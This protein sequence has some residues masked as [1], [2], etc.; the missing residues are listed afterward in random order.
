[1]LKE[2]SAEDCLFIILDCFLSASR[3]LDIIEVLKLVQYLDD[4]RS[5]SIDSSPS[6]IHSILS[7]IYNR[8]IQLVNSQS[9]HHWGTAIEV[10]GEG[11]NV[12]FA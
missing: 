2:S 5:I 3:S 11:D 8:R 12:F 7:E 10:V 9:F 6:K 1:M 4:R